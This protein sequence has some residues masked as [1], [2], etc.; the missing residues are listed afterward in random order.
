MLTELRK[1]FRIWLAVVTRSAEWYVPIQLPGF[2]IPTQFDNI[3]AANR[4]SIVARLLAW[5]VRHVLPVCG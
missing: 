5:V 1:H 2:M 4:V 3:P